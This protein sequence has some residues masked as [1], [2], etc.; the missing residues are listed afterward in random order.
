MPFFDRRIEMGV[1][2]VVF[3]A[4]VSYIFYAYLPLIVR[5]QFTCPKP[6]WPRVLLFGIALGTPVRLCG[7][8]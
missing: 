5:D 3:D 6:A 2:V 1:P 8:E 7:Q 4:A